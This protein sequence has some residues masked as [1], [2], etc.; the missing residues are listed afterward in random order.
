MAD[1]PEQTEETKAKNANDVPLESVASLSIPTIISALHQ[2]ALKET[3]A[4]SKGAKITNSAIED[5]KD[6]LNSAGEHIISAIPAEEGKELDKKTAIELLKTYVQWFVGPD[7]AKKVDSSTVKSLLE[8]PGTKKNDSKDEKNESKKF[9][10]FRQYLLLEADGEEPPKFEDSEEKKEEPEE[11]EEGSEPPKFE[12]DDKEKKDD[13]KENSKKDSD[14]KKDD[15]VGYYIPYSLKVEGL[16]QTALKDSMKKFAKTFFDDVKFTASGLFGGGDSFT[17]K[18]V[19][20]KWNEAFGPI[21]P[22]DLKDKITKEINTKFPKIE[23]T[24]VEVQDQDTLISDLG[25]QIDSAQKKLIRSSKYSLFIKVREFDPKKPLL[26]SRIIADIVTSSISGLFKKFK[27][28][29]TK[30]DVIYIQ[31]YRD[32]HADT[33]ALKKLYANV[34]TP[35]QIKTFVSDASNKRD[36]TAQ[37]AFARIERHLDDKIK[38]D[39]QYSKCSRAM[40]CVKAWD[41]QKKKFKTDHVELTEIHKKEQILK[42]FDEFFKEYEKAFNDTKSSDLEESLQNKCNISKSHIKTMLLESLLPAIM[43][44]EDELPSFEEN[45]TSNEDTPTSN[46]N[47]T[48]QNSDSNEHN[49]EQ[50]NDDTSQFIAKDNEKGKE[51]LYIVP[52]PNMNYKDKEYDTYA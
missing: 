25:S 3:N 40:K 29:I 28:K 18:D 36:A 34:P 16:P 6:K 26:N 41:D 37:D 50:Q 14:D 11:K 33:L 8:A 1:K 49:E 31:G 13:G 45:L 48:S 12:G 7:L 20:D 52:I 35:E 2:K 9:M 46:S 5:G 43:L 19:K 44:Y 38:K 4:A 39:N 32:E 23:H 27:N 10:S 21:D 15:N 51:D 22:D 42:L 47:D 30:N 17:V 24:D